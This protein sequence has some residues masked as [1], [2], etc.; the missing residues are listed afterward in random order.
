MQVPEQQL[1]PD[2]QTKVPVEVAH[3]PQ[4]LGSVKMLVQPVA[5]CFSF[6]PLQTLV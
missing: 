3:P 4:L 6:A 5:H 2:A 1:S